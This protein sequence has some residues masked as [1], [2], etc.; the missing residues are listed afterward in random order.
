[1]YTSYFKAI[2]P[3]YYKHAVACVSTLATAC[4]RLPVVAKP[5]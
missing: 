1:M 5:L 3:S 2:R 4:Y